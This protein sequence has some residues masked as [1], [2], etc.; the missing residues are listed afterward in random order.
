MPTSSDWFSRN[1]QTPAPTGPGPRATFA[2]TANMRR[3]NRILVL[4]GLAAVLVLKPVEIAYPAQAVKPR[5]SV[6]TLGPVAIEPGNNFSENTRLRIAL[7]YPADHPRAFQ[8]LDHPVAITIEEWVTEVYDGRNGATR[9][10]MTIPVHDG[11]AEVTL[12]S[13]ASYTHRDRRNSPVPKVRV[14]GPYVQAWV[15]LPQWVDMDG[16]GKTDWLDQQVEH[17]LRQARRKANS[18]VAQVLATLRG[19][20]ES[21]KMDCGGVE[22]ETP[23]VM[24]ISTVCLD[25]SLVNR[26]RT[27]AE[28]ELTATVLHEAWHVWDIRRRQLAGAL[29]AYPA[30]GYGRCVPDRHPQMAPL[31]RLSC[32]RGYVYDALYRKNEEAD[33]EAFATRFRHLFR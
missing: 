19:W 29:H 31:Y 32:P 27:N 24:R 25:D 23:E 9:L 12:K 1:A 8:P 13:V 26:H 18:E 33:A 15:E 21:Y 6:V 30:S 2:P 10:P 4:G 17:L 3:L 11:R 16:N 14:S 28:Q 5:L 7:T 22:A 20:Q